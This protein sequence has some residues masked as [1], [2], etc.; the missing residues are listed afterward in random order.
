MVDLEKRK[1]IM[2]RST[3]LGHCICKP[4]QTCPCDLF[5]ERDVCQCAGERLEESVGE[6][7]LTSLT[8][9]P[10]C[11]SKI[12]QSDLKRVLACLPK[13]TDPR[14]LVGSGT[15]DDAGVYT[16]D[17]GVALVQSV[18][19]FTPNVDAPHVFGQVA[20]ANSLSDIYA[21]GGKPLTALS[22]IG[23]PAANL[24]HE[25]MAEI[26]RGGILKM[27]EAGVPVIGGHSINDPEVKFGF[28]VTGVVNPSQMI[29][30]GGAEPGDALVLT[31][32]LGVGVI[33]FAHQLGRAAESA[34]TAIG[35]SMSELN[36]VA[37]EAMVEMGAHA[38][39]DVTGFGLLGHLSE[40]ANQSGVGVEVYADRVPVFAG[41]LDHLKEGAVSGAIERNKEYVSSYVTVAEDV[42]EEMECVLYDPQTSGGLLIAIAEERAEALVA[43]LR[44]QGVAAATVIGRV[45]S[46]SEGRIV[47]TGSAGGERPNIV[48]T[49][50]EPPDLSAP[51][52]QSCCAP[53][54]EVECCGSVPDTPGGAIASRM[55]ERFSDFMGEVSSAGAV[56]LRNKELM[57]IGLS[58]LSKCEPCVRIHTDKA[59][60][61]GISEEEIS[62]AAWM[63]VAFGGAPT[64]MFYN[65][66]K[67]R[68]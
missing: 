68:E 36:K 46:K 10:G 29:T 64:L 63:A 43:R 13:I 6:V 33:S 26:L 66:V 19:V 62:E 5:K 34:M 9:S 67:D 21:M 44:G 18:D 45:T 32:P 30:N 8:E 41:V 16:L 53:E 15:C 12:G 42:G 40:M 37:A 3:R 60:G 24:S 54:A 23:F 59:R 51:E 55:R 20:A 17:G 61:L 11:A 22:I 52:T 49:R 58:V 4:R 38:A 2:Q 56:S 57:A 35:R 7:C 39:T 27:Q 50:A 25:V 14:V 1:R 31:K 28:A 47:V 48:P 65:S